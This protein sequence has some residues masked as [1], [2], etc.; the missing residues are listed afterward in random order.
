[1][2]LRSLFSGGV[3]PDDQ[4]T[5]TEALAITTLPAPGKVVIPLRQ[6]IGAPCKA[7]VEEGD[8][9]KKGQ[10]IGEPQGF[11]SS[12]IHA[13]VSGMVESIGPYHHPSGA[14]I[15][16]VT[17]ASDGKDTLCDNIKSAGNLEDLSPQEIRDKVNEAGI[18][19]MGGA[20]FPAHV[21]LE[22]PPDKPS[23]DTVII[24]GAECE[25]YLT[26][27]HRLMLERPADVLYGLKAMM[28]ALSAQT[29]IIG[30]EKN[31]PDA[32][33]TMQKA[34]AEEQH[35]RVAPLPTKYPQGAEKMLIYSI[36]KR[37]IPSGGLPLDVGIVNHNVGTAVAI[38]E[39]LQQGK[40]LIER[41][42]TVT[43]AGI[44]Q[45]ANLKVRIGTLV[46]EVL[47]A[48]GGLSEDTRKLLLGGP[49]MGMAQT[50]ADVP[51]LKGTSGILAMTEADL[52][53]H[54]EAECI[55]CSKCVE[56]CPIKLVP[57]FIAQT[58]KHDLVE[59]AEQ[60]H[61]L[62]CIE[63]GCCSFICPAG[64][65]LTKLIR[66]GKAK[67]AEKNKKQGGK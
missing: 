45:P 12:S 35:I 43:G 8:K 32:L 61:A 36:T 17:I 47:Q 57:T 41:V 56:A 7:V 67:I 48:Q 38:T 16:A 6:H 50:T 59:R 33:E 37:E 62:D 21:K 28:K 9:V 58:A 13:S 53:W 2:S 29:G 63:C 54:G 27:D 49:M 51:V 5:Y 14:L 40:P 60:Y 1:M 31:K 44:K 19:G 65:P 30:I 23:I 24:N 20:A 4:K 34:V 3:H 25:P 46:S 66:E 52:P 10:L 15:E 64:I 39:A 18:V 22:T 42:V 26:S 11:V 55:K